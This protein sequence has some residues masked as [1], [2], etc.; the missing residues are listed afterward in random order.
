MYKVK[1]LSKKPI[2]IAGKVLMPDDEMPFNKVETDIPSVHILEKMGM[3]KV[4][5]CEEVE[6][7]DEPEKEAVEATPKKTRKKKAE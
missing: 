4:E 7:K 3:L 2:G 5:A 6:E 1:N